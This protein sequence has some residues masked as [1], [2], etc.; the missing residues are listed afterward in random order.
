MLL[1]VVAVFF[2]CNL[3]PLVINIIDTFQLRLDISVLINISNLLV[4]IN[5]SVNFIIYVIFG[6]KFKR[7]FLVLFCHN[8]LFGTGRES[9]D[10]ATHEDSFMSN[11]GDR[12]SLRLHRQNT[13]IS[14]NGMSTRDGDGSKREKQNSGGTAS[15]PGPRI[16]YPAKR[17][18][19]EISTYTTQTSILGPD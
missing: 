6:E 10:G 14:S 18:G 13:S 1:C 16:Y 11:G 7:L 9:P 15:S 4:T 5:S 19:K 3:L 17:S 2:V 8:S 12:H